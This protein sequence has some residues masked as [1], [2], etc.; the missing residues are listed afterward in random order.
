[1]SSKVK[2]PEL[3]AAVKKS[4]AKGLKGGRYT[5]SGSSLKAVDSN[6]TSTTDTKET[7]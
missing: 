2:V 3:P 7:N 5:V 6:K 4:L 1:M